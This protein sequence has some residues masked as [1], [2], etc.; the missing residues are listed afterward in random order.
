MFTKEQR[1]KDRAICEAATPPPWHRLGCLTMDSCV[2]SDATR[3]CMPRMTADIDGSVAGDV[4]ARANAD[5]IAR[6]REALPAYIADAEEME[7]RIE[8]LGALARALEAGEVAVDGVEHVPEAMR[9]A[10]TAGTIGGLQM[11]I[12]SLRGAQ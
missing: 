7:R 2:E 8:T 11:A 12:A 4:E 6:A 3:D 5:L 1:G 10:V 9:Y